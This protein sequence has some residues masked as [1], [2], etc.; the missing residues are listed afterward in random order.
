[1]SALLAGVAFAFVQWGFDVL[2]RAF[3]DLWGVRDIT[4]PAGTADRCAPAGR[5]YGLVATPIQNTIIRSNESE[6]D[7]Y[8]LNA[9]REPDGFA[10]IALKLARVPQTR[11]DAARGVHLLRPSVGPLAHFDGDALE[12][13]E[14]ERNGKPAEPPPPRKRRRKRRAPNAAPIQP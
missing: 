9:A 1:M 5:V 11:S 7:I 6:A 2:H 3:G 10:T 13:G 4:D 12:G 8:G 14:H